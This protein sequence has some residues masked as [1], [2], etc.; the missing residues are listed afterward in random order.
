MPSKSPAQHR[1]MEA[2]A[3]TP[4]GYGGVSQRVG[5]DFANA[6]KG[7]KFPA[8]GGRG[9]YSPKMVKD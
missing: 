9:R 2:A 4:G 8:K 5:K 6:D 7:K 3:H 1:L